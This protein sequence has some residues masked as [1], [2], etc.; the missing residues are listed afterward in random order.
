MSKKERQAYR[1]GVIETLGCMAVGITF[2]SIFIAFLLK[3][4]KKR[5][6]SEEKCL[7]QEKTMMN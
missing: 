4:R 2:A 1:N 7:Y 6:E 3:K 5:K